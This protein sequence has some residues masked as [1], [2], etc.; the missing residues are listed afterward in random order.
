MQIV[1]IYIC[2]WMKLNI[3]WVKIY[4]KYFIFILYS[5][6]SLD[7]LKIYQDIY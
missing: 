2:E 3:N 7:I 4:I 1:Y 5:Y 6:E